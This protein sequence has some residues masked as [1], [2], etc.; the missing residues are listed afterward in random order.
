[1]ESN[2]RA[3]QH[4]RRPLLTARD[5]SLLGFAAVHRLILAGHAQSLLGVSAQVA[6]R[7]M[8]ALTKGGYLD[9]HRVFAGQPACYQIT[10]DGLGAAGSDLAPPHLD[11]RGYAHDVG[12]AWLW[13]AARRGAFGPL[14]RLVAE[15]TLRSE[16]ARR[17]AAVR[18]GVA[19]QD[20]GSVTGPYGVRL[21]GLGAHGRERLHYPDL[22]LV[23]EDGRRIAVELELTSKGQSRREAILSGYGADARV[24][25]VLYLVDRPA[26][27]RAVEASARR[28]GMAALVQVQRVNQTQAPVGGVGGTTRER[29]GPDR[30]DEPRGPE[31]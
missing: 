6:R 18:G 20:A 19:F 27:G 31:R 8:T 24:G 7:R 14:K 28:L 2:S 1:M 13:L 9:A 17:T 10:R 16:D 21:G 5:L 25:T 26:V 29:T 23:T 3:D 22:L 15:R 4:P 12:V 30:R 11:V